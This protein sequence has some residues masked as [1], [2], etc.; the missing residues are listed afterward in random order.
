MVLLNVLEVVIYVLEMVL[1]NYDL[2]SYIINT[3]NHSRYNTT[4]DKSSAYMDTLFKS[5]ANTLPSY[6]KTL[7]CCVE[8][9]FASASPTS[10]HLATLAYV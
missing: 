5:S 4:S 1:L 8:I 9:T 7:S 2:I 6:A 3:W 10:P